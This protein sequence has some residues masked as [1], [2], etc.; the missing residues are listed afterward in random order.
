[1]RRTRRPTLLFLTRSCE[2]SRRGF[3]LVAALIAIVLIGAIAA[4]V[5]FATTED[6]KAGSAGIA[7]DLALMATESAI[8]VSLSDPDLTLPSPIGVAGTLSHRLDE[9]GSTVTIYI[10]R[11]DSAIYWIVADAVPD[12]ARAGAR[13]RIGVVV[14]AV[15]RDDGSIAIDP[16]SERYWSELF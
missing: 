5:V 11:L 3:V 16:I 13:R 2:T 12:P 1:M 8:A 6:T 15:K 10:T 9:D 7:R 4:G 14:N